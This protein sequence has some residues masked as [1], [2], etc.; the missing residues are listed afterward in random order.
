MGVRRTLGSWCARR[1]CTMGRA[2][3]ACCV[4]W[5]L[6]AG[7]ARAA[8][9]PA[10][11]WC[12][13]RRSPFIQELAIP[14]DLRCKFDQD[15]NGLDDEIERELARCVTPE[16]RFDAFEEHRRSDEPNLV[17]SAYRVSTNEIYIRYVA[18][19][20]EDGGFVIDDDWPE[21]GNA[22]PGDT[23]GLSVTVRVD[24]IRAHLYEFTATSTTSI[25]G[26]GDG[27][28]ELVGTHPVVYPTAGK[29]HW[30]QRPGFQCYDVSW[31]GC[32]DDGTRGDGA[33]VI[34][35]F[36]G[37]GQLTHLPAQG[38][39]PES[40][41]FNC[42]PEAPIR[43][44]PEL[45]N[46]CEAERGQTAALTG[47]QGESLENLGYG[48]Q[49]VFNFFYDD[50][51][52]PVWEVA[53]GPVIP[54]AD[55][56]GM[57]EMFYAHVTSSD[58]D[59]PTDLCPLQFDTSPDE[60]GDGLVGK[61]DPSAEFRNTYVAGGDAI[62]PSFR[63][64]LDTDGDRSIDGVDAC[65]S[66][67]IEN[68]S[69]A[70][71]NW[72]EAGERINFG[73]DPGARDL[74]R[75]YRGNECDP[76]PA[77][78]SAWNTTADANLDCN[79]DG[80]LFETGGSDV[81]SFDVDV[82]AGRS[83][84]DPQRSI[85]RA[86]TF[87][88][89]VFRCL[90][91]ELGD[92]LSNPD[93][94]CTRNGAMP[95]SED[96]SI[97]QGQGFR[98]VERETCSRDAQGYCTPQ[99]TPNGTRRTF[100]WHWRREADERPEHFAP[101][102]VLRDLPPP[103][104]PLPMF[105][106]P[107]DI[108]LVGEYAAL[109][110]VLE[111]A[112]FSA[113]AA[114]GASF[115]Q[116]P[117]S[118]YPEPEQT[119]I[120]APLLTPVSL[121]SRRLRASFV[122]AKSIVSPYRYVAGVD[123]DFCWLTAPPCGAGC[124]DPD[125]RI[126]F[127]DP[128]PFLFDPVD[129]VRLWRSPRDLFSDG[130]LVQPT[131]GVTRRPI[132]ADPGFWAATRPGI[133]SVLAP[134]LPTLEEL[135]PTF[136]W[137]ER[138]GS[139]ARWALLEPAASG[140]A[141]TISYAP[142]REGVLVDGVSGTARVLGDDRGT[143]AVIVDKDRKA[144]I[145]FDP[146]TGNWIRVMPD[147]TE[148]FARTESAFALSGPNLFV[149][150]GKS[151]STVRAD[152]WL[153]DILGG[154]VRP[155]SFGLPARRGARLQRT[156]DGSG[157]WY[158]GGKDQGGVAHDDIWLIPLVGENALAA[159]RVVVDSSKASAFDPKTVI[160]GGS[161]DRNL[162]AWQQDASGRVIQQRRSPTGWAAEYCGPRDLQNYTLF[163]TNELRVNDGARVQSGGSWAGIGSSGTLATNIGVGAKVG[164]IMSTPSVTLRND[165]AVYGG[166]LSSNQVSL[167]SGASVTGS[168][169]TFTPL[170]FSALDCAIPPSFGTGA[171]VNVEGGQ[172]K[173]LAPGSYAAL[174]VKSNGTL[175]LSAGD[176]YFA[177]LSLEPQG[178]VRFNTV[179][180]AVRLYVKSSFTYKGSFVDTAGRKDRILV[181]YTGTQ[182]AAIES[183]FL[184]TIV[185]PNAKIELKSVTAPGHVGTFFGKQVELHQYTTLTRAA[186]VG[187]WFN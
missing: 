83:A 73:A 114:P 168:V 66:V 176:Y 76:Y 79:N 157:L 50:E 77:T 44:Q 178:T 183:R 164:S 60:D 158:I 152:G 160:F 147:L 121:E 11:A 179:A 154:V 142:I 122:E 166:V 177:S 174:S 27:R 36:D 85:P 112:S 94:P 139:S 3:M 113:T 78:R 42:D 149:I 19:F 148:L 4:V 63:G 146:E 25:F 29:H 134:T 119:N 109:S 187:R 159:T 116:L 56:D 28:T 23:Q 17:F 120:G 2:A 24:G 153:I 43:L 180:G 95:A 22:H 173:T 8:D 39:C 123:P 86:D 104:S 126:V 49:D 132:F 38:R 138:V 92:C 32:C 81:V 143:H 133:G 65:P 136:V 33:R 37:V 51:A 31:G 1:V 9:V 118:L 129:R 6:G 47:F 41:I 74:G 137:V 175:T 93:S 69:A 128:D 98:P 16:F 30:L 155:W 61:C 125:P 71:F 91:T 184:G 75:F 89:Q 87:E 150:G 57:P 21:C 55:G 106:E 90:C 127:W 117:S 115:P 182:L 165:A 108:G 52:T 53:R 7:E 100:T 80:I 45:V 111:G 105:E 99:T 151:G 135:E 34:P 170:R 131:T 186:F 68:Y 97:P 141:K 96:P 40:E 156:A 14:E 145:G 67:P 58:I 124:L 84:N 110:Q 62:R 171:A 169:E 26:T 46:V 13:L 48:G 15:G 181:V 20:R 161:G 59:P 12:S 185:A 140:G 162:R 54:D 64:Y 167:Q 88:L 82:S 35:G 72:N 101:G 130:I 144:L 70:S 163:A 172:Q 18:L 107:P 5:G 102:S 103:D 10:S